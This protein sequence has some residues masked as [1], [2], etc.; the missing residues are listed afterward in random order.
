MN[1]RTTILLL[2]VLA[3]AAV[4]FFVA[5]SR[6]PTEDV[7]KTESYDDAGKKLF[8]VPSANVNKVVVTPAGGERLAFE[9]EGA[10][11]W[12]LTEP[13]K[14]PADAA[15]V[16][17]LVKELLELR[18]TGRTNAVGKGLDQPQYVVEVTDKSDKTTKL[19]VGTR[20]AVGDILY[21]RLE[22]QD[23]ADLVAGKVIDELEKPVTDF[24]RAKVV[25]ATNDDIVGVTVAQGDQTLKLVRGESKDWKV[26][27]PQQMPGDT[28]QI[29]T[30]LSAVT[31]LKVVKFVAE[32]VKNPAA[33]GL[34]EPQM[35]LTLTTTPPSARVV[36][37][38]K[39]MN[40]V[41]AA[42]SPETKPAEAGPATKPAATQPAQQ[43]TTIKFGRSQD[44]FKKNVFATASDDGPVVTVPAS[45]LDS[46]KKTPLDLRD[47]KVLTVTADAVSRFSLTV[48]TAAT[49]QPTTR[50]AEKKEVV[51]E[52]RSQVTPAG[53]VTRPATAPSTGPSTAPATQPAVRQSKWVLNSNPAVNANDD[54]VGMLFAVLSPLDAD[55]YLETFPTTQTTAAA[56]Y[57]I[58]IKTRATA[59]V[60]SKDHEVKI[61][62]P[63]GKSKLICQYADATF[64]IDR[65]TL[66]MI[67]GDFVAPEGMFSGPGRGGIYNGP[68]SAP[69]PPR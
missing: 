55:R 21:V 65:S 35:T 13:V 61:T 63:G 56:T 67:N 23:Q 43:T 52:P 1:F 19:N 18:T 25:G 38:P 17:G 47:R 28:R 22:G 7:T 3:A 57:T 8:D 31:D 12:R 46:F 24:R 4:L 42:A 14:G 5:K 68:P 48:E 26:V 6:E 69:P 40:L 16:D 44:V 49:T 50:P 29:S 41:A 30:L 2:V 64:E 36:E 66:Q 39:P 15:K 32:D 11:E 9:R 27:E 62:D 58:K 60:P 20:A 34:D 33:Y 53:P 59:D 10:S 45:V 54:S 37:T 51:L